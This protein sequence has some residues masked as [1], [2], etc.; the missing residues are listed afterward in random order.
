L[1]GGGSTAARLRLKLAVRSMRGRRRD[2][3]SSRVNEGR[4]SLWSPNVVE[5]SIVAD[6]VAD[7]TERTLSPQRHLLMVFEK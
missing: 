2:L 7:A 1:I 4:I 5:G 3:I 6:A